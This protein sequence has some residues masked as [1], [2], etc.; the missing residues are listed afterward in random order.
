MQQEANRFQ[1]QTALLYG[2]GGAMG[3]A[4]AKQ[5]AKEGA[6]VVL[7]G[8]TAARVERVAAE[9]GAAGGRAEVAIVD[10]LDE[11]AVDR[12]TEAVVARAGRLDL[13]VNAIGVAH[14]Q[15]VPLAAL[16]LE[17]FERP[18]AAYT[19][20]AFLIARAAARHLVKQRAGVMLML[21]VPGGRLVGPGWL[22]HGAAYAAMDAM[23]RLLAA[24]L[25]P[26]G[27]RVV[28]LRPDA[29]PEAMMAPGSHAKEMLGNAAAATGKSLA[30]MLE[31][32]GKAATMLGRLPKLDEVAATAAF[33]LS[34]GAGAITATIVNMTCGSVAE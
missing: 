16:T 31:E 33:L 4:I 6:R 8:R 18:I 28:G 17:E 11:A 26:H 7:A 30:E 21:S 2:G 29:T 15:G 9:I 5:L 23:L 22:G 20:S 1:G 19:R 3:G 14:V 24:E 12:A 10:A 32:R 27:V 34:G 13:L 25:G